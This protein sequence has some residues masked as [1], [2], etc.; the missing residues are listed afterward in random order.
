MV[1]ICKRRFLW[2]ALLGWATAWLPRPASVQASELRISNHTV[3]FSELDGSAADLDGVADGVLTLDGL[4]LEGNAEILIDG[5]SA[6]FSVSGDVELGGRSAILPAST[7]TGPRIEIHAANLRLLS[8]AILSAD[9]RN[10]GGTLKL[11]SS[12]SIEI[13]D[14][15]RILAQAL[16]NKGAGGSVSLEAGGLL[17]LRSPALV[18]RVNGGSGGTVTLVSCEKSGSSHGHPRVG[19]AILLHGHIDAIGASGAGGSVTLQARQGGVDFRPIP[20]NESGE[21]PAKSPV[22]YAINARGATHDGTVVIQGATQV[23]PPNPPTWPAAT[24]TGGKPSNTPCD[25]SG[26]GGVSATVIA[27]DVDRTTGF[28]GTS[29]QLSGRVVSSPDAIE[30]WD[31]QLSDGQKLSG[32]TVSASFSAPGIYSAQLTTTDQGGQTADAE[33]GIQVFDPATQAAP[34]LG[35]PPLVGDVDGDG[36]ITLR[37]ALKIAQHAGRLTQ[38][39]TTSVPAG[40]VDLDSQTT[41]DDARL[42]AQ[43]V[44]AGQTLPSV[45]LPDHGMPGGIV[46]LISPQL[47]D[48]VAKIEVEFGNSAWVQQPLRP[49]RGYA[50]LAVPLDVTDRG[51]VNVTPGPV[52]VRIRRDGAVVAT[53][54]FQV[55]APPPLPAD[56][57]AEL[58]AFLDDQ[59]SMLELNRDVVNQLLQITDLTDDE[60]QVLIASYKLAADQLGLE[61]SKLRALLDQPGGDGLARLFFRYADAVGY[62]AYRQNLTR[63]LAIDAVDIRAKLRALQEEGRTKASPDE[64]LSIFCQIKKIAETIDTGGQI[65][66]W[67]CDLLLASALV[68]A[69]VPGVGEIVDFGILLAWANTCGTAQIF[70]EVPLLIDSFF[71]D[72]SADLDFTA[73][74]EKPDAGETVQLRA[75]LKLFGL[76]SICS[77]TL[78]QS[79]EKLVEKLAEAAVKQ[80]FR[81]KL[82]LRALSEIL[83]RL[84]KKT[85]ATIESRL[86][87]TLGR[88]I[89]AAGLSRLLEDFSKKVCSQLNS[90]SPIDDDLHGRLTGPEPNVG[91]LSFSNDG[92]AQYL[93]P[94]SG[95]PSAPTVTFTATRN[96]CSEQIKKQ[97]M[98]SCQS[99]E[100][101]I[102]MGDNGN[103]LDDIFEVLVDGV[104]VLTSSEPVTSTS[105]TIALQPGDHT[106]EMIGRAAPDGVGTYFI[107]FSG[108]TLVSGDPLSGIDLTPGVVKTFIINVQ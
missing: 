10:A 57:K 39:P 26:G 108:A 47:L 38:L 40:D 72:A 28:T 77:F 93:C 29:F 59:V 1:Q 62:P 101:T 76:E 21:G 52:T 106:V 51:T 92:S 44:A 5:P 49:A 30:K 54:I 74:P 67:T 55:E 2:L 7:A 79:A 20:K 34:E 13:E 35:L 24:V 63:F 41:S 95:S 90:G 91:T 86:S 45:L 58:T 4:K 89:D 98:V 32:Q 107:E 22:K 3:R 43:A 65:L 9:G 97:V 69:V 11:C 33:I 17:A 60:K 23:Y 83:G 46:N 71:K 96:I 36:Q 56:P 31:W 103:L 50:T 80:F 100:V 42:L 16:D 68:A 64:L 19:T 27:I 37:D 88:T 73:T 6:V 94:S 105:T 87:D 75:K 14:R 18:V 8:R 48:P 85:L 61:V 102:T 81:K 15:A 12:G 82:A 78:D 53:F 99:K 66:G 70:L 84:S 104:T 25:C